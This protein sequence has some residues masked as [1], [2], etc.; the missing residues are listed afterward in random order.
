M[1]NEFVKQVREYA[2]AEGNSVIPISAELEEE[3]AQLP[4]EEQPE[5]LESVGLEESGLQRLIRASFSLLD[6][7]TFL[8]TG[9][10]ESRAWTIKKGTT[11]VEA[12]GKI[13]TD[14]QKGFVR[15]EVVT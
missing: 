15:A 13:H 14:I 11:A 6:L 7:I 1:E 3:I 4:K 9:E 10:M 2:E 12:A 5:F 8:T